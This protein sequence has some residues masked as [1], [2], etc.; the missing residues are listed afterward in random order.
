MANS[1]GPAAGSF[2]AALQHRGFARYLTATTISSVGDF[3]N[4]VA[5]LVV[6]YRATGSAGWLGVV[7]VLRVL[8]WAG[9]TAVGGVVSDRRDR[10]RLLVVLNVVAAIVTFGLVL[11]AGI[12]APFLVLVALSVGLDLVAGLVNPA[13]AAAVPSIVGEEDVAAANAAVT[14]VEQVSIVAGPAL[15]ALLVAAFSPE[16]AFFVNAVSYVIAAVLFAGVP[17][18]GTVV[19]ED[20]PP[21]R[22]RDGVAAVR[23]SRPAMLLLSIFVAAVFSYGFS[24][25]LFVL[26]AVERLGLSDAGVGYLRMAEGVGGVAAAAIAGRV[27]A[28]NSVG[29][30]VG[31]ALAAGLTPVLL[32]L[33]T[34]PAVAMVVLGLGGGAYVVFEVIVVSWLQRITPDEML[35]RVMGLL[36]SMG[37][38]G[39][40]FG[41]FLAPVLNGAIGLEWTLVVSGAVPIGLIIALWP[42]LPSI[43]RDAAERQAELAPIVDVLRSLSI[44]AAAD[45]LTLE[46]LAGLVEPS[47]VAAGC[48]LMSEGDVADDFYVVRAG[49]LDVRS[50]GGS[51][52]EATFVNAMGPDDW[53]GEIGLLQ[54]SPRTATVT[55][56]TA[57][58]LWRIPGDEFLAAF[59]GSA[60]RPDILGG[61]MAVRLART[62]PGR[63]ADII[64]DI[65]T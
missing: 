1:S 56:T 37:A 39:T 63:A 55:T 7:A 64:D 5:L 4:S 16:V 19:G 60:S 61:T 32:A 54:R 36:M 25:V 8:A 17:V 13:C 6:I 59:A 3:L 57:A 31:T 14:T 41:A 15:G 30:L 28:K 33:T 48:V 27:A 35:G 12:D 58:T 22:F 62:H 44:F 65:V 46:H 40:A 53:F 50:S 2:R 29:A 20:E 11:A 43:A 42:M 26:V 47:E 10:R 45:D 23:A 51:G 21:A 9:A 49:I 52:G 34:S 38:L 18:G 24:I